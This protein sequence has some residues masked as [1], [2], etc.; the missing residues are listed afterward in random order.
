MNKLEQE[1][2]ASTKL[3][4]MNAVKFSQQNELALTRNYGVSR[5][6]LRQVAVLIDKQVKMGHVFDLKAAKV[7]VKEKKLKLAKA[8]M[9]KEVPKADAKPPKAKVKPKTKAKPKVKVKPKS[10]KKS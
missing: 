9:P 8:K 3:P 2:L 4:H 7:A 1:L 6:Q 10:K 5:Q